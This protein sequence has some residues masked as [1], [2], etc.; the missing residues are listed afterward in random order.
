MRT[1]R[2]LCSGAATAV[3][4]L[5][6]LSGQT[7]SASLEQPMV[8]SEAPASS[9]PH[10]AADVE[11]PHPL[12]LAVGQAGGSMFVGGKFA[13]VENPQ[14]TEIYPRRHLMAFDAA[15]GAI[16]PNFIPDLNGPVFA[17]LGAGDAVYVG[18][19]FTSVNGV[20]RPGLAKLSATTGAVIRAFK[21]VSLVGGRVSEIRLVN[22]RLLV[23]GTFAGSL[24]A[25]DPTTGD[26]TH[27]IDVAISGRLRL[28][29][30]KTE[31]A[32]FAVNPKG[33]RLVAVGNFT[34]VD[35][36]NRK[37]AFMLDL[38]AA[39]ATLGD[40][41]YAPLDQRCQS[42]KST[43]Q[44][45]LEDVDFSPD[46]TYFVVVATGFV[47]AQ[48]SEIGTAVCDAAAR[49][50]TDIASPTR[51]TW[52]NYTGGDTLHSVA[53]TGAA[54]YV[55]G[56]NR[57]L[58]N[59]YGKD[60]P[61]PGAVSRPGIGAIDPASGAALPWNPIKPAEQGG[62]DFLVT[63]DG[64]WVVSDSVKFHGEYHRGIAFAPL[65]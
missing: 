19:Q 12:A 36:Q 10:I 11:V 49:F 22:N 15:T 32:K 58:D 4:V 40:W 17:V 57:W 9:T 5:A 18:G 48:D 34:A 16:D 55:Q 52:I 2:A 65:L 37:R 28:T 27:Y 51:P 47:P 50:E 53:A 23:S 35:G 41:Y 30:T 20:S 29:T 39:G 14:R 7:A 44:A 38:G 62:H 25:L 59:P 6:A 21:P 33:T 46:G 60:N 31:V 64:L 24:L 26:N 3:L 61:G 8:V 56:H 45:Y 1:T 54:V 63:P 13:S 43:F 42:R